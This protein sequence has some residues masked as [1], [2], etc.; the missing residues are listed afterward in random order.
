MTPA[1]YV[2]SRDLPEEHADAVVRV[3][4]ITPVCCAIVS[5]WLDV[6]L[7]AK[8]SSCTFKAPND[9]DAAGYAEQIWNEEHQPCI[10]VGSAAFLDAV[11]ADGRREPVSCSC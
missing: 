3:L 4:S 9:D 8:L 7:A 10:V 11:Y 5:S 1:Y 2:V 6:P